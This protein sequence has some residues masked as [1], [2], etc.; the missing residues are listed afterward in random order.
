MTHALVTGATGLLGRHLVDVLVDAGVS[1]RALVRSSSD[2]RHLQSRGVALVEGDATDQASLHRATT[3]M[4][5]V[6]HVAGYLTAGSPFGANDKASAEE[7]ELYRAI[8]VDFT[9]A[10]LDASLH[11]GCGRFIFVSSSSV[12]SLEA[13]VPTPEDAP[14]QP[15][16][17]Y[18][19]SKLL[20][21]EKVRTY[22]EKGLA[23]TIIRPPIT[24]GPGDR[25]FTPM[26]L[27]LARLPI[28][29]LI[30]GGRN[31]VDL[32]FA[33]DVAE[34]MWLALSLNPAVTRSL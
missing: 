20:A 14:L 21:E 8:N 4:D 25:Y 17:V 31:S 19:R 26:V 18:G 5:L 15:F 29:P 33:G 16:S 11:A 1:V 24:Y 9:E 22:Q 2:T 13:P 27:R 32:V 12:Y 28:L 34:L 7:W 23:S 3:A 6:F 30:N 10:M